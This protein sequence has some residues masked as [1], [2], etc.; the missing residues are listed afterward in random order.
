MGRAMRKMLMA[1]LGGTAAGVSLILTQVAGPLVAQEADKPASVYEQL[2]P[3]RL[4]LRAHP[5]LT[6]SSLPTRAS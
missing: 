5:G 3:V 1:A 4:D 6:T 2:A